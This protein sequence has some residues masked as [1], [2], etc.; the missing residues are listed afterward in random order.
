MWPVSLRCRVLQVS[1]PGYH[2]HF[3]RRPRDAQR[4]HL[5]DE[6]LHAETR[7]AYGWPRI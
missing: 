6:A 2:A 1:A 3:V 4:Q 7:S 5:S